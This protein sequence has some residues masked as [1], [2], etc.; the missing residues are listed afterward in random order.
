MKSFAPLKHATAIA[1]L[2]LVALPA[3]ALPATTLTLTQPSGVT[4][5]LDAVPIWVTL[6]VDAAAEGPLVVDGSATS[7]GPGELDEFSQVDFV[8]ASSSATCSTNFWPQPP[9]GGCFDAASAWAFSFNYDDPSFLNGNHTLAPG[10]SANFILGHFTPQ[11]G[12][13][14]PGVYSS[15]NFSFSLYV[16]GLD[17]NGGQLS[18][19][20]GLSSTC[21]SYEASCAFTR[22]VIAVPEPATYASMALGLAFI[23]GFM[24]RRRKAAQAT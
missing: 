4:N 6:T 1:A 9:L 17:Q 13:V 19:W 24:A 8:G 5:G 14:A 23:G 3:L 20:F 11:N 7:F 15:S 21:E 22:E 18:R 2:S 10:E 12:Q 16:S